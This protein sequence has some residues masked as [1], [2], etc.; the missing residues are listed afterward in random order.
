MIRLVKLEEL[1]EDDLQRKR[2]L[3]TTLAVDLGLG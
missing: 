2:D 3:E 1:R